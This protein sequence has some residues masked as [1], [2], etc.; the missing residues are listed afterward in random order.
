MKRNLTFLLV[1]I[2]TLSLTAQTQFIQ[3][4]LKY[5][6]LDENTVKVGKIDDNNKPK[7]KLVIP[8]KVKH[9]GVTYTV[10]TLASWGFFG[11]KELTE[12]KMP[13]TL[14]KIDIWALCKCENLKKIDIPSSVTEIGYAAFENCEAITEI[15]LPSGITE[16]P[17]RL[18]SECKNLKTVNLP[19]TIKEIGFSSFSSCKALESI[20]IPQG[21]TKIDKYA[22]AYCD[23]LKD[24][25]LPANLKSIGSDAFSCC[26]SIK[27]IALPEGLTTISNNS[28][29]YCTALEQVT[30]PSTLTSIDGNPFSSCDALKEYKVADGNT[31][32]TVKDGILFSKDMTRLI[33]C[34][35]GQKLGEYT[36]PATVK[37]IMHRAFYECRGLTAIKM[38]GVTTIGES[39][40]YGCYNLESV[41]F[42]TKL[43]FLAKGAFYSNHKIVS[44]NLPNSTKHIDMNNFDFCTDLRS[45]SL[46]E[47]LYN[48][49]QD[50]NN[51]SFQFNS[52][53]LRFTIR[54]PDGKTKIITA[55]ELPDVKKYF[56][57]R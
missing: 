5:T 29:H 28:F 33:A 6:I 9:D 25:N 14:K 46:S 53:D 41:D 39:A 48:R 13:S 31:E 50:F 1:A 43:E 44:I 16:V 2:M 19:S 18:L 10:T 30:L 24:I 34:P 38:T 3:K 7:G 22:F 32:F 27:S 40:F 11:C 4:G 42:G 45:V 21:V 52:S 51:L 12:I 47:E 37:Y 15:T 17:E 56:I 49:E 20:T 36:V 57:N 26:K 55:E 23:N 54:Q 8:D 35:V